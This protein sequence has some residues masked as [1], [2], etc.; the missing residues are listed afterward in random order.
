[1]TTV[2]KSRKA[3]GKKLKNRKENSTLQSNFYFFEKHFNQF[4]NSASHYPI[5]RRKAKKK[6]EKVISSFDIWFVFLNNYFQ[7]LN[8]ISYIFTHFFIYIYFYKYF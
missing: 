7:F 8:N 1:M 6:T 2:K 4:N 5:L 3:R